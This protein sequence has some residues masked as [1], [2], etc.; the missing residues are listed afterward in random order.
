MTTALVAFLIGLS[1][2]PGWVLFE[3]DTIPFLVNCGV[4]LG[5]IMIAIYRSFYG[6]FIEDPKNEH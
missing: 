2:V 6:L 3:P 1:A 5:C 4:S